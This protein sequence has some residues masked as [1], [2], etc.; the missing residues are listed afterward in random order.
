MTVSKRHCK[1]WTSSSY[2]KVQASC[3]APPSSYTAVYHLN[4]RVR[5]DGFDPAVDVFLFDIVD[6]PGTSDSVPRWTGLEGS[7]GRPRCRL[8]AV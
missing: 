8:L 2:S 4:G 5:L 6:A 7:D 3:I 1:K